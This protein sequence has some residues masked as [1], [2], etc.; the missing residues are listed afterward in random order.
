MQVSY[1]MFANINHIGSL[2]NKLSS[3][4]FSTIK[5]SYRVKKILDVL[6]NEHKTFVEIAKED[7][8]KNPENV[9]ELFSHTFDLDFA[10]LNSEELMLI[11]N[12]TP[13]EL[14]LIKHITEPSAFDSLL[15]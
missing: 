5:S 13:I 8:Y 6:V 12:I 9:K 14:D 3:S 2:V 15:A 4:S 7:K 10:P 11:K 1:E